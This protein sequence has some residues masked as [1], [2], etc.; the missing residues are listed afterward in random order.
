MAF[1]I[2]FPTEAAEVGAAEYDLLCNYYSNILA[3]NILR[4][5]Y[6][7][8]VFQILRAKKRLRADG[9][10]LQNFLPAARL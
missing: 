9:I 4:K 6:L 1:N 5:F 7:T 3:I 8:V 2:L 10:I